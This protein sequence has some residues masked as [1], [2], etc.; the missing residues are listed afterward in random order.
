MG[1]VDQITP[2]ELGAHLRVV[3]Q[4]EDSAPDAQEEGS[5]DFLGEEGY[6]P[7]RPPRIETGMSRREKE[8]GAKR[9]HE[10]IEPRSWNEGEQQ[11]RL[12]GCGLE[13]I[14]SDQAQSFAQT[15]C[16]TLN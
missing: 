4:Q 10:D 2:G 15:A 8:D 11:S 7:L 5:A 3:Q 9:A 13:C 16:A 6:P 14:H 12:R 1:E